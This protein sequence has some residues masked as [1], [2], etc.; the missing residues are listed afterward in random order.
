MQ[1]AL[2]NC[3]S[4]D[5]L[6][7][8]SE[9]TLSLNEKE[10]I[11]IHISNCEMCACAINGFSMISYTSTEIMEL[12]KKINVKANNAIFTSFTVAKCFI[13]IASVLVIVGVYKGTTMISKNNKQH[14]EKNVDL[15]EKKND[16]TVSY[17]KNEFDTPVLKISTKENKNDHLKINRMFE[18]SNL[19]YMIKIPSKQIILE[20]IKKEE[21]L[22]K[23]N[24]EISY[25]HNLKITDYHRLYFVDKNK[26]SEPFNT[27]AFKENK[28]TWVNDSIV[29]ELHSHKAV[30]L[31]EQG[32]YYFSKSNYTKALVN[33]N[34]LLENN[35]RDVNANFYSALCYFN[36]ERID[37]AIELLTIVLVDPSTTFYPEA[38]W[39]LALC[40]LKQNNNGK[41]KE[42]F[43]EIV[44]EKGFYAKNAKEKL[45]EF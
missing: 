26:L 32:L 14:V 20:D 25:L 27:L 44:N 9:N 31:L 30:E 16:N 43:Q 36:F 21:L 13:V 23:L 7:A 22:V 18:K 28:T 17:S 3:L 38:Q 6:K 4:F 45:K 10:Q 41:A 33:F 34:L 5:K 37:K 1:T 39:H 2:L 12:H 8:Y 19:V 24:S 11:Y 29:G 40:Y 35:S 42:I 15:R